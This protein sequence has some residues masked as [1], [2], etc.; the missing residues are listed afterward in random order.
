MDLNPLETSLSDRP[1]HTSDRDASRPGAVAGRKESYPETG[2]S[3]FHWGTDDS[4]YRY[5]RKGPTWR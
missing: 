5:E 2:T 4:H 3:P 1:L